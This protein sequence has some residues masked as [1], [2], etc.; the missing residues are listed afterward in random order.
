M[1]R[2]LAATVVALLMMGSVAAPAQAAPRP[3]ICDFFP[4]IPGC[5]FGVTAP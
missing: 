4:W 5:G 2:V 3:D 1:R